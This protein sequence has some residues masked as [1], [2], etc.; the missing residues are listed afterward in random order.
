MD[1]QVADV[2]QISLCGEVQVFLGIAVRDD[3]ELLDHPVATISSGLY[4]LHLVVDLP[5]GEQ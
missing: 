4:S 3:E 1:G 5:A 2:P